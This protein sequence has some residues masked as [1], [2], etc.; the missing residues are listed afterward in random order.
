M[1]NI[2][3]RPRLELV[4]QAEAAE[5]GLACLVMVGNYHGHRIQLS[6]LRRRFSVSM[7]GQTLRTLTEIAAAIGLSSRPV[8]CELSELGTIQ[9]P[10][11]LHWG[12]N[13]FV[14]LEKTS[15]SRVVVHDPAAGVLSLTWEQA[16]ARFT[17][18]A[19]EISPSAT[20]RPQ[21]ESNPLTLSS[22]V[23]IPRDAMRG[24][25]QAICLSLVVEL[26]VLVSPLYMQLTIDQGIVKED[27]SLLNMLALTFGLVLLFRVITFGLRGFTIQFISHSV[28]FEMQARVFAHMLRLP[29]E[30]FHKRHVGDIQ[31]RFHAIQPIQ[32]FIANGAI[33]ALFD[34]V[35]SLLV[36]AMM[37]AYSPKLTLIVLAS[38]LAYLVIR[39]GGIHT[40]RR[41]A[42]DTI[43]TQAAEQTR[44][45]ESIR[46]I[47]TIKASG[48]EVM[49]EGQQRNAIAASM[50]AMIRSGNVQLVFSGVA[51]ALDGLADILVVYLA[52]RGII[53]GQL[54][55]GMLGA[56]M[57]YKSQFGM[58]ATNLVEQFISWR[59]LSIDLERLSDIALS[60][61]ERRVE[62]GGADGDL[63]G[64]LQCQ[65]LHFAYA[66][67]EKPV[68][69]GLNL[70]IAPGDYVA[71]IGPSGGGKS[72]LL[73]LLVGLYRPTSGQVLIDGRPVEHWDIKR[74]RKQIAL[75]TQD[76][77][78][79]AGS[80]AENIGM[81]DETV[82]MDRV[83]RCAQAAQ[84]HDEIT[85][86]PMAY[87]TLVGDMGSSLSG[88]QKQR[89][90]IARALYRQP[91]IL[92]LD[93]GTSHLDVI[94]ERAINDALANLNITRIV[95]AHRPETIRAADRRIV[96]QN[97]LLDEPSL[98][99][100]PAKPAQEAV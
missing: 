20:F 97:G 19:L 69:R 10:A 16:S 63:V 68:L 74:L 29:L 18:V 65:D 98:A 91:R 73:K 67:G 49:R 82:D 61:T 80:I 11:I 39:I 22:L 47:E 43:V 89:V 3:G 2:S 50:N 12:G 64:G 51:A 4:R 66:F 36:L 31:S 6:T 90:M 76:D 5:C 21:R 96:L 38:V 8:R 14:V 13:H 77:N 70:R 23:R 9:K 58:R 37:F 25:L 79:L 75:V 41:L 72:T 48:A 95:V 1:L 78:L 45:L 62:N 32:A 100:R 24:L 46:A 94:N 84:I 26:L 52:A 35:L 87:E 54:S 60:P 53:K 27:V 34:S 44:F 17:G 99:D 7:K 83:V 59:M 15:G 30:W 93:E 88:G 85:A 57:A 56:F 28:S 55:V 40:Q 71:I 42:G 92:I 86:M 33:S 81:F